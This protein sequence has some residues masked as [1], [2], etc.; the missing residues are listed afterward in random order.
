VG[1]P[2]EPTSTLS[3]MM[4]AYQAGDTMAFESL[5]AQ[6]SGPVHGYLQS[7]TRDGA[8]ADALRRAVAADAAPVRRLAPPPRRALAAAIWAAGAIFLN[9]AFLGLR[10]DAEHLGPV[11][12]WG[13]VFIQAAAGVVLVALALAA[14]VPGRGVGTALSVLAIGVALATLVAQAVL[15]RRGSGGVEV[16]DPWIHHGPTCFVA[17]VLFGVSAFVLVAALVVRAEPLRATLAAL[18]SGA[19]GGVMAEGIYRLHCGIT[20]LRHV[21]IWHL[22]AVVLLSLA[23]LAAGL[24]WERRERAL[25]STRL[26]R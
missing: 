25:M 18:L 9:L 24:A 22:G 3:Q 5:Y 4:A 17:T 19:G 26:G 8:R 15:S 11:L 23:G 2:S 10:N 1:D 16:P 21:L 12:T 20:D 13:P 7:L 6:L 14:A